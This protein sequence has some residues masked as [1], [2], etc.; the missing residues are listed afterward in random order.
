[1]ITDKVKLIVAG[2]L[3]L[4]VIGVDFVSSVMSIAADAIFV[5]GAIL[6]LWPAIRDKFKE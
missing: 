2:L 3:L 6:L 1:M 5:G 4:L